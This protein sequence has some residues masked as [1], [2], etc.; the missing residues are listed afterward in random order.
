MEALKEDLR[1]P[2][3]WPVLDGVRGVA[4]IAVA[5][6]HA[7]RLLILENAEGPSAWPLATAR[8]GLDAFFVL[9]GLLIVESWRA[10][11]RRAD[12]WIGAARQYVGRRAAR[13]LPAYWVSLV[14]LVPLVAGHL[15]R[16][17]TDL[18]L[19]AGL[20]GYVRPGLPSEVN[21]VYWSLTTEMHFYVLAPLLAW[22]ARRLGAHK[23][24]VAGIVLAVV[25]QLWAAPEAGLP[26]SLL[27]GRL[28]QFAMGAAVAALIKRDRH[29]LVDLLHRRGAGGALA[30]SL[31]ALGVWQGAV[32]DGRFRGGSFLMHS[33]VG[34]VVG[35]LL[36][37]ALTLRPDAG[38]LASRPLR[39]AGLVSYGVYLWHFPVMLG[40][41]HLLGYETGAPS[42]AAA[43]GA[44]LLMLAVSAVAGTASYVIVERPFLRG[45]ADLD[46]RTALPALLG[47]PKT[48]RELA[49]T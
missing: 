25:W 20:Q 22:S 35:L 2:T 48:D 42:A 12:S 36:L 7:L 21:V 10:N 3:R 26:K 24:V 28:D 34:V 15:L 5:S 1:A 27:P 38:V 43:V 4:V 44:T 13:I 33:L 6:F 31:L 39:F 46:V 40:L 11:R 23:L 14:V 37:R 32:L 49:T 19:L 8:F 47:R 30:G 9:S 45:A 18:A 29:W 16:S 17:P 41:R